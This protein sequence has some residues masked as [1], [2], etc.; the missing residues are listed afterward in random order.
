MWIKAYYNIFY[1]ENI[2][3]EID[4]EKWRLAHVPATS[5]LSGLNFS[6]ND[7]HQQI[8]KL[9]KKVI[10]YNQFLSSKDV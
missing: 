2:F 5:T 10:G 8:Q 4:A 1:Y 9:Q 6:G 3:Y 7:F